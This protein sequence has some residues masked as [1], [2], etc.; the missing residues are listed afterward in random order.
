[1]L[2]R[3]VAVKVLS[4][5]YAADAAYIARLEQE[6]RRVAE[7]SHPRLVTVFDCGVDNGTAY[8]V[9]ELVAGRT[10]RQLLDHAGILPPARA[11]G[12]A[13]A[14]CEAL[15][16][17]H[18]VGL[19]HGDIKPENIVVSGSEARVLDFGIARADDSASGTPTLGALGTVA[20]LSP[21]Q[22]SGR[23]ARPQS[24]LYSLGCVLFEML[25]GEPRLPLIRQSGWPIGMCM[26]IPGRH[27]RGNPGCPLN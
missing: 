18:A 6:T 27:R 11:V 7:L 20:Y 21:E 17:A 4:R 13:A 3:E 22:A 14:V 16:V 19:V 10:L 25:T 1:M 12:I 15:E 24:D 23:P 2:D 9:M 8:I 26:T 5:Q